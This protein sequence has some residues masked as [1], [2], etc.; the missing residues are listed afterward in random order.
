MQFIPVFTYIDLCF[1]VLIFRTRKKWRVSRIK[2]KIN[3]TLMET[4]ISTAE[5]FE[6]S[7]AANI[8]SMQ[9]QTIINYNKV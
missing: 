3:T 2:I 8:N 7:S 4:T 1:L 9:M 5:R 6:S